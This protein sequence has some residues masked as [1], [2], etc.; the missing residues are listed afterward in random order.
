MSDRKGNIMKKETN[1]I[2]NR[3]SVFVSFI[4]SS[5]LVVGVFKILTGNDS[6][7]HSRNGVDLIEFTRSLTYLG[8]GVSVIVGL[9]LL[10]LA[11]ITRKDSVRLSVFFAIIGFVL[12]MLSWFLIGSIPQSYIIPASY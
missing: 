7:Q 9:V 12:P 6:P 3:M 8:F 5:F 2:A 10:S 4:A 11:Y 1:N